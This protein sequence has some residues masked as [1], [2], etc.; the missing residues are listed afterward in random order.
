[1]ARQAGLA[2]YCAVA[3]GFSKDRILR[4]GRNVGLKP[5]RLEHYMASND[6]HPDSKTADIIDHDLNPPEHAAIF[7]VEEEERRSRLWAGSSITVVATM[8]RPAR[9]RVLPPRIPL[10][11][12]PP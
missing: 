5:H 4:V 3:F 2:A 11:C 8:N 6:S 1:M 10:P 7:C 12:T 9:L